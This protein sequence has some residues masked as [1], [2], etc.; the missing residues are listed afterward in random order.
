MVHFSLPYFTVMYCDVLF[1]NGV[2]LIRSEGAQLVSGEENLPFK[3]AYYGTIASYVCPSWPIC[4][5]T[6]CVTLPISK[7]YMHYSIC[8]YEVYHERGPLAPKSGASGP[9]VWTHI[10]H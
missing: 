1:D 3:V 7:V 10:P 5:I 2:M 8:I 6:L 9:H 4:P